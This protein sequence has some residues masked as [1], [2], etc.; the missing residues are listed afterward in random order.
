MDLNDDD[1]R[2]EMETTVL[3]LPALRARTRIAAW[4]QL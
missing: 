2:F 3:G 4:L 1:L